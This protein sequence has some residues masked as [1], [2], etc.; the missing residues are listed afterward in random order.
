MRHGKSRRILQSVFGSCGR[1]FGYAMHNFREAAAPQTFSHLPLLGAEGVDKVPTLFQGF[2]WSGKDRLKSVWNESETF[3]L[4]KDSLR[5]NFVSS[6][7][8]RVFKCLC[9]LCHMASV[10]T[11]MKNVQNFHNIMFL[12]YARTMF[13]GGCPQSTVIVLQV[14]SC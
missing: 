2:L 3:E 5:N 9:R 12:V 10:L 13:P 7:R 4:E 6:S 11:L 8:K 1:P 14:V